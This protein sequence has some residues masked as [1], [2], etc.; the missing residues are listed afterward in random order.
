[1]VR[2]KTDTS[3]LDALVN[4]LGAAPGRALD[5][6]RKV[7]EKGAYNIKNDAQDRV[8]RF[9]APARSKVRHYP[10]LVTYDLVADRGGIGA[11]IGPE[12]GGQGS[13]GHLL[14]FGT[15]TSG[16]MP[17]LIPAF[18]DEAPVVERYLSEAAKPW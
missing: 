12:I 2:A 16:A 13:L 15:A 18:L 5:E 11:E 4:D 7:I 10:Y 9:M 14:E 17:H 1:M 8:R 6:T 3:E